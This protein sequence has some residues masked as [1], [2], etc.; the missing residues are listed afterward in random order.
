M[1]LPR[2]LKTYNELH[3][4]DC[5]IDYNAVNVINNISAQ[6]AL[7]KGYERGNTIWQVVNHLSYW[8][9][10]VGN[11]LL[12]GK[13]VPPSGDDFFLP[14]DISEEAW[15]QTRDAFQAAYEFVYQAIMNL[16]ETK[17]DEII[18]GC[19]T[20]YYKQIAGTIE[21]DAFHLGQIVLLAR[22]Q[23]IVFRES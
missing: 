12:Y 7:K 23:G 2:L 22:A 4:G 13:D 21:H 19:E 18:T 9:M 10:R 15:Q 3:H 14:E 8:R 6:Q 1:L 16:D 11:R 5:W 20:S 17:L